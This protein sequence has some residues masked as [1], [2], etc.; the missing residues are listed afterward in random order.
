MIIFIKNSVNY[1]Y[2][3]IES[4][5]KNYK[6]IINNNEIDEIIY[7]NCFDDEIF[8]KY[9]LSKYNNV[10]FEIP[11]SFDYFINCTIY[12]KHIKNIKKNSLKHFYICHDCDPIIDYSNI[13][14]LSPFGGKNKYFKCD[15][16][17]Y[18]EQKIQSD[19]PIYIIQGN[20]E[21][22]RRDFSLLKTILETKFKYDFKIKIVGKGILDNEFDKYQDKLILK[23]DLNF[24]D[25]HKEFLDCYCILPL[26]SQETHPQ[27]YKSKLTSTINYAIGYNLKILIDF[28][29]QQIYNIENSKVYMNKEDFL[30]KFEETLKE[31]YENDKQILV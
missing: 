10:I 4:V 22:K 29:L 6:L 31:F 3:I 23:H 17:P 12:T 14:Y 18:S 9:I 26:I 16:L 24:I 30:Q 8:K 5:I 13:F 1:H 20:I 21:K 27:Y 25:Y 7:I 28:N 2:E 19:I 11:K 15:V